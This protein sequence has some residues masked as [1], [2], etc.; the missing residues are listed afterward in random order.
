MQLTYKYNIGLREDILEMCKISKNLY[1]QSLYEVNKALEKNK[2][3][4]YSDLDKIMK[5]KYNLE[6]TINYRL[7]KAKLSQKIIDQLDKNLKSYYR[8]IKDWK[9]NRGKY[10]GMPRRPNYKKEY[11]NLFFTNQACTIK[12][13]I[14]DSGLMFNPVK[15]RNFWSLNSLQRKENFLT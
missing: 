12:D 9:I 14:I 4:F 15:I 8:S 3:L 5:T 6:G 7:L 11:F 1:N 10:K 2:F 13:K